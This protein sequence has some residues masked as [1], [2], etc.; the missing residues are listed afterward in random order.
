[1]VLLKQLACIA[2]VTYFGL[3]VS[4]VLRDPS[5]SVVVIE[6]FVWFFKVIRTSL[7]LSG[8]PWGSFELSGIIRGAS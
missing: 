5:G 7:T 1:M 2:D 6:R 3:R 4:Q 8:H